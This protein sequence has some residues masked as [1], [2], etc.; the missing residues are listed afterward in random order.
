ML[1]SQ[2]VAPWQSLAAR[3]P[4]P[5]TSQKYRC[6]DIVDVSASWERH[7]RPQP[8]DRWGLTV[9]L[10]PHAL[11]LLSASLPFAC[12]VGLTRPLCF[13]AHMYLQPWAQNANSSGRSHA[14]LSTLAQLQCPTPTL[15]AEVPKN[16]S[17][18]QA[19]AAT[20]I[21]WDVSEP[22]LQ[23]NARDLGHRDAQFIVKA[24]VRNQVYA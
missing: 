9:I 10:K 3:G 14:M 20:N 11:A 17:P 18:P 19:V 24:H 6:P 12:H 4:V 23:V 2:P 15:V 13:F 22:P 5:R 8:A 16:S 7:G 21:F 1:T